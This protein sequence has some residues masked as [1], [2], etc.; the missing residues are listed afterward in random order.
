MDTAVIWA[1]LIT[2]FFAIASSVVCLVYQHKLEQQKMHRALLEKYMSQLGELSYSLLSCLKIYPQTKTDTSRKRWQETLETTKIEI[3][4]IRLKLRYP[5]WGIIDEIKTLARTASWGQYYRDNKTQF[6]KFYDLANKLR[7]EL[8]QAILDSY[9]NG[10]PPCEKYIKRV[11]NAAR[12]VKKFHDDTKPSKIAD[13]NSY[14]QEED[15][16]AQLRD[17][18]SSKTLRNLTIESK[19]SESDSSCRYQD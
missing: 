9:I 16:V 13:V 3:N 11:K 19:Q 14:E 8:D 12:Q 7:N 15:L 10:R 4:Q 6:D 1:A 17:E 2:S 5:L 18:V